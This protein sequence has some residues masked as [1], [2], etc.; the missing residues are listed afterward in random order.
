MAGAGA[1]IWGTADAFRYVYQPLSGDG[2]VVA[3]VTSVQNVAAWVKAGVM[4]RAELTP[5]SAHAMMM[6]TPGKGNAFQRRTAGGGTS[7]STPGS[8]VTAPYWVKLTRFGDAITAYESPDGLAWR[9]VG[10]A[11]IPMPGV[12]FVGLAL[13]SHSATTL[14]EATFDRVSITPR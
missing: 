7:N 4:I 14:A 11:T 1:D 10:T 2:E 5:G 13:S 12:V 3:R 9:T 8:F 6:V